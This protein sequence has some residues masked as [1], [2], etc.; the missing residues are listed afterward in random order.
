VIKLPNNFVPL[1]FFIE[2]FNE[3]CFETMLE[4]PKYESLVE[5]REKVMGIN[6]DARYEK[7]TR[8]ELNC[9]LYLITKESFS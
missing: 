8:E 7:D 6:S 5:I 3:N 4:D 9:V 1:Q 2:N